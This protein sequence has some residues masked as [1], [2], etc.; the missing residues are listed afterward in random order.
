MVMLVFAGLPPKS[1]NNFFKVIA[2]DA[3]TTLLY[4]YWLLAVSV[5]RSAASPTIKV[6]SS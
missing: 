5:K 4:L 1:N 6:L 3:L 2:P